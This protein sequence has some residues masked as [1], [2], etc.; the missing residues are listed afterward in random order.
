MTITLIWAQGRQ[1]I[2]GKNNDMPWKLPKDMAYFKQQTQH[3]TIVMGRKTW[4]SFGSKPLPNRRNI[5]LTRD[6]SFEAAEAEV[7]HSVEEA[8]QLA[9][10][11]EELMIIGGS[12]I[13]KEFLNHADRLLVTQIEHDFE[14]DTYFPEVD[15]SEWTLVNAVPGIRDEKNDY[16]YR[17]EEYKRK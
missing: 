17:F 1:G 12:Q 8:I 6:A 13:Y 16:D 3:K 7:L 10:T 4:N 15:W 11:E 5:I 9:G 14:G 2:I